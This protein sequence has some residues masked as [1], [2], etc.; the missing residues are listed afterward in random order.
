MQKKP[1]TDKP[2]SRVSTYL[3]HFIHNLNEGEQKTD[4]MLRLIFE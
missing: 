4:F 1:F 3:T 2:D